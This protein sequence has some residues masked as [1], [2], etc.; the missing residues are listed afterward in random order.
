[1]RRLIGS[2]HRN[3]TNFPGGWGLIEIVYFL[4]QWLLGVAGP[5]VTLL[6]DRVATPHEAE[7]D[8]GWEQMATVADYG[9][10][11]ASLAPEWLV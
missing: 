10:S 6:G 3:K 2:F 9:H 1:M 8:A 11:E 5:H 4:L 7:E